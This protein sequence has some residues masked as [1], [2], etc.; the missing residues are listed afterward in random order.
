MPCTT[1]YREQ[2]SIRLPS[3]R[4]WRSFSSSLVDSSTGMSSMRDVCMASRNRPRTAM[5]ASSVGTAGSFL[6]GELVSVNSRP[7][8]AAPPRKAIA[9]TESSGATDRKRGCHGSFDSKNSRMPDSS[10]MRSLI[11]SSSF[12]P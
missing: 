1:W 7:S 10:S 2:T 5:S 8:P 6:Q 9:G 11:G 4:K 3:S 12:L